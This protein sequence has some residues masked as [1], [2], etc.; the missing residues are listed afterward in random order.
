MPEDLFKGHS[1]TKIPE[2]LWK[3]ET[4]IQRQVAAAEL[5]T[6]LK[7]PEEPEPSQYDDPE[8]EYEDKRSTKTRKGL[9]RR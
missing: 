2:S 4:P 9:L 6:K 7:N 1:T 8:T 3:S 5:W